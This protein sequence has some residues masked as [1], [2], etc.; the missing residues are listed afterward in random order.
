VHDYGTLVAG[1]LPEEILQL[2]REVGFQVCSLSP[3]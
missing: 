1:D 3:E 2:A